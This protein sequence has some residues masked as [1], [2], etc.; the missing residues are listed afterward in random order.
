[1]RIET[2][3]VGYGINHEM[4]DFEMMRKKDLDLVLCTPRDDPVEGYGFKSLVTKYGITLS[5]EEERLLAGLPDVPRTPVGTVE[6]ALEAK[7]CMTEHKKALP[8]L[9]DELSSSH[10]AIHGASNYAIAVGYVLINHAESFISPLRNKLDIGQDP[11]TISLH[12]QPAVA[13]KTLEKI[14]QLPRRTRTGVRGFDALGITGID[15][16]NDGTRVSIIEG[17]IGAPGEESSLHYGQMIRR[18]DQLYSQRFSG[19]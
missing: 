13:V 5:S 10:L 6:I 9:H 4:Q 1:M 2:G 19:R 7:A 8:R 18:I 12:N 3:S 14:E 11:P 16:K 15:C 17:Q